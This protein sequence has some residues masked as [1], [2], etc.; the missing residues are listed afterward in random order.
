M[1]NKI[2]VA[3][4]GSESSIQAL[5]YAAHFAAQNNAELLIISAI[6]PLPTLY[7]GGASQS[8]VEQHKETM[9]KNYT[10]IQKMH[11]ERLM[12]KYPNLPIKTIIEEGKPVFVIKEAAIDVDLIVI[13]HRGQGAILSWVLGS[14]AKQIVD[15]CTVPVLVVKDKN[16]CPI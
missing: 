12:V 1:F 15:S 13:G 3:V 9:Y 7:S 14:V 4:D 11:T 6:E 2:L 10:D 8:Y 16:Y 5:D